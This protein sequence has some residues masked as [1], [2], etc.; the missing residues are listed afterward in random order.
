MLGLVLFCRPRRI[1]LGV[2]ALLIAV[3]VVAGWFLTG[4]PRSDAWLHGR[5]V[6]VVAP[7]LVAAG[8]VAIPRYRWKVLAVAL[9]VLPFVAGVFAAW[10]GPGNNWS[11]PRSPV[12]MLG[13][14][15]GGAPFGNDV[16]EPGAAALVA[17]VV[18]LGAWGVSRV[19]RPSLLAG[20]LALCVG[21][22]VASGIEGLRQLHDGAIAGQVALALDEVDPI[23]ELL[24]G[25]PSVSRNLVAAMAWE[26]G[27]DATTSTMTEQTTH[28]LLPSGAAPP[29]EAVMVA[30]LAG[31]TL[32]E[33]A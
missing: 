14:E 6:E 25:D 24:V 32:W 7:V 30:D 18:G 11:A 23:E 29:A 9:F 2:P 3:V 4:V 1:G 21:M 26:V 10:N 28:V 20:W 12:M 16:F 15:V 19:G 13:V 33:L 5:Y 22:G 8:V 17:I 27:F 31:G